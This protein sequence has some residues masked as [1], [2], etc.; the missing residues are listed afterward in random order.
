MKKN[1]TIIIIVLVFIFC[2]CG[3]DKQPSDIL[4]VAN[5][6]PLA[7]DDLHADAFEYIPLE[8][9]ENILLSGID[10]LLS[11]SLYYYILDTKSQ[12]G[13]YVFNKKGAFVR[14][15]SSRGN[16]PGEFVNIYDF[17]IDE[18][19]NSYLLDADKK[20]ILKFD[21][22]GVFNDEFEYDFRAANFAYLGANNFLFFQ[23]GRYQANQEDKY[24]LI[25][26]NSKSGKKSGYIPYS[27]RSVPYGMFSSF[28]RSNE[29]IYYCHFFG[30]KIYEIVNEKPIVKYN[31]EVGKF[32][33]ENDL[34]AG[35]NAGAREVKMA[36]DKINK[37]YSNSLSNYYE[38]NDIVVFKIR[39][40]KQSLLCQLWKAKNEFVT[41][42]LGSRR[43]RT[44]IQN[45]FSPAKVIGVDDNYFLTYRMAY[46]FSNLKR[47]KKNGGVKIQDEKFDKILEKL[48]SKDNPVIVKYKFTL[49]YEN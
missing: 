8:T 38:T 36:I 4:P 21:S 20:R 31:L 40:G 7:L 45:H 25:V 34:F 17:D 13:L 15:V 14:T 39:L 24:D 2:S 46:T 10:K 28:Y 12:Y 41:F 11:D 35:E 43:N 44:E 48:D 5:T 30:Y 3:G 29:K 16:G 22:R 27:K 49:D 32:F 23:K 6:K 33:P 9:N 19:G 42:D 18:N 47:A 37:N 26:W 1:R